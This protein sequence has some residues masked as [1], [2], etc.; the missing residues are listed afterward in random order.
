MEFLAGSEKRFFDFFSE[1]TEKDR[2]ALISHTDLDGFAS[3]L[4]IYKVIGKYDYIEFLDYSESM[5]ER[6]LPEIKKRK[7]NKIIFSDLAIDSNTKGL[8]EIRKLSRVLIIDHHKFDNDLN[9]ENIVYIKTESRVPPSYSCYSLLSR[10]QSLEKIDWIAACGIVADWCYDQN[11]EFVDSIIEKYS[12]REDKDIKKTELWDIS[13]NLSL[14]LI[15]FRK[16]MREAF[17]ILNNADLKNFDVI[18]TYSKKVESEI[19]ELSAR[20]YKERELQNYGYYWNFSPKLKIKSFLIN[21]L[22]YKEK[23]KLFVFA[24]PDNNLLRISLRR[25]DG[26]IDC[27][28]LAKKAAEGF[29]NSTMGGHKAAA[30]GEIVKE[31][32]NKFK[33]NLVTFANGI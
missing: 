17:E 27:D 13:S 25:Q 29:R 19:E 5:L 14:F 26:K 7:I 12:L 33:E 10:M 20:F 15:Y 31:D 18:T 8:E 30:G 11:K 2:I 32:E 3:A 4:S 6:I 28:S 24:T 21:S 16:N 23:D 22:S 1:L 9:S